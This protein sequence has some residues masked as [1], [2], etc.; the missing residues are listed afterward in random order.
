MT[1]LNDW[2]KSK[3]KFSSELRYLVDKN[4]K[5]INNNTFTTIIVLLLKFRCNNV[6]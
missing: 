1:P 5:N 3:S 4:D 2:S 6:W